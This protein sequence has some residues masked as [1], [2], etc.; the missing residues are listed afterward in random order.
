[1]LIVS[2]DKEQLEKALKAWEEKHN[3]YCLDIYEEKQDIVRFHLEK[4]MIK[5]KQIQDYYN[6]KGWHV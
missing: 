6:K 2:Y 5:N 3:E 4:E 1:M